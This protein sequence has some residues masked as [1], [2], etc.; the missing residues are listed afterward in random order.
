M[1]DEEWCGE[2]CARVRR[3]VYE[4]DVGREDEADDEA[5]VGVRLHV[6]DAE[7]EGPSA[8]FGMHSYSG[9]QV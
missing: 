6:L 1:C 5:I 8:M 2:K 4:G 9:T 7:L 3:R